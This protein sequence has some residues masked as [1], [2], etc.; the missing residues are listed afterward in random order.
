LKKFSDLSAKKKFL[1][2]AGLVT[3]SFGAYGTGKTIYDNVKPSPSD[4]R[5]SSSSSSSSLDRD[6]D[7]DHEEYYA[8]ELE[9]EEKKSKKKKDKES[10]GKKLKKQKNSTNT[11]TTSDSVDY[12]EE[13]WGDYEETRARRMTTEDQEERVDFNGTHEIHYSDSV[14]WLVIRRPSEEVKKFFTI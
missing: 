10:K 1:A 8:P 13:D 2:A 6:R 3:T 5:E 12:N 14:A 4:K 11:E 7:R 9:L